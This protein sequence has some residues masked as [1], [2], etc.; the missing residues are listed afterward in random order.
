MITLEQ[1]QRIKK[2]DNFTCTYCNCNNPLIMTID[3]I[4]SKQDGGNDDD[5]NLVTACYYCNQMKGSKTTAQFN[6]FKK[7]L[8][9]LRQTDNLNIYME[10]IKFETK[11]LNHMGGVSK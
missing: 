9:M 7:A 10:P 8:W 2:R 11:N 6:K 3:H 1:K 4:K 5:D